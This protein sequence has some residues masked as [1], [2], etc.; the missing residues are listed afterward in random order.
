M[1]ERNHSHEQ[2]FF[3]RRILL[4]YRVKNKNL[5]KLQPSIG[6]G[7]T[8]YAGGNKQSQTVAGPQ[9]RQSVT[10]SLRVVR[11]ECNHHR[12]HILNSRS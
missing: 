1:D 5:A 12:C 4:A 7:I 2:E 6:R 9:L 3:V 11:H 10:V 8:Q